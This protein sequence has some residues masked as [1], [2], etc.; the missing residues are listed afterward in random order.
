[1]FCLTLFK[2][3]VV[4]Y[5]TYKN[6]FISI[7]WFDTSIHSFQNAYYGYKII[8]ESIFCRTCSCVRHVDTKIVVI[9]KKRPPLRVGNCFLSIT[10]KNS[11][12]QANINI[13]KK[14]FSTY[15]K[16]KITFI[17]RHHR[18]N[19]GLYLTFYHQLVCLQ[20][21]PRCWPNNC[22]G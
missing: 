11:L 22:S 4:P 6:F 13:L 2:A 5:K 21:T 1:M 8:F 18:A 12:H 19:F 16:L 14:E 3:V 9:V 20:D 15:W 7:F 17:G 10:E